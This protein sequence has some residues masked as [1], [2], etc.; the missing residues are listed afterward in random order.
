MKG[1]HG[2]AFINGESGKVTV[3]EVKGDVTLSWLNGL[4]RLNRCQGITKIDSSDSSLQVAGGS[5]EVY[6]NRPKERHSSM[7]FKVW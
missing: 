3:S 1:W 7:A 4:I 2:P 5:G 6:A